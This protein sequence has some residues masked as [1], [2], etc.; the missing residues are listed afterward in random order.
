MAA[1]SLSDDALWATVEDLG[2]SAAKHI[3]IDIVPSLPA[4]GKS[5]RQVLE[6]S[7]YS[8]KAAPLHWQPCTLL[9]GSVWR[10]VRVSPCISTRGG[11]SVGARLRKCGSVETLLQNLP[12]T[13]PAT[14][15]QSHIIP[16]RRGCADDDSKRLFLLG[17]TRLN[18]DIWLRKDMS[19]LAFTCSPAFLLGNPSLLLLLSRSHR[20]QA[21]GWHHRLV[22]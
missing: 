18:W 11:E 2:S 19:Q 12:A 13:S 22:P 4:P 6:T 7:A 10:M 20:H 15:A 8:T 16:L 17:M 1:K 14:H 3:D 9:P 5:R 21:A